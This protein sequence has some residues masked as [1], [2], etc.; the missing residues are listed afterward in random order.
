MRNFC[1][2]AI[3]AGLMFAP[4][5]WAEPLAPGKPA[6]VRVAQE[7]D[8]TVL[9]VVLGAAV[10]AGI[11]IAASSG[12]SGAPANNGGGTTTTTGTGAA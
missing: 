2:A 6:G 9:Y 11:A 1:I 5:A 3:T 8:N 7:Q 12:S 4:T 10:I